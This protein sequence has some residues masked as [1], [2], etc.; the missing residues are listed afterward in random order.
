MNP[1]S[2]I[3]AEAIRTDLIPATVPDLAVMLIAVVSVLLWMVTRHLTLRYRERLPKY[4][5]AALRVVSAVI[6]SWCGLQVLGRVCDL[7]GTMPIWLG[8]VMAGGAVEG[9]AALYMYER[10]VISKRLGL[11]RPGGLRFKL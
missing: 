3:N 8:A 10:Q 7:T 5:V 1:N 4:S 6:A 2:A 9:A 11:D